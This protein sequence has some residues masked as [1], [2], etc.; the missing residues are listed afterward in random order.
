MGRYS[1]PRTQYLDG[2]GDPYDS[3]KLY[4]Y[5]A[6]TTTALDTY[7]DS[8]LS[9]ANANPVILDSAGRAP[10]SIFLLGRNY[11]VV[12]KDKNDATI[13]T[14]D[15]VTADDEVNTIAAL[16]ALAVPDNGRVVV[17]HGYY[18]QGDHDGSKYIYDSSS[19]ATADG[20]SVITPDSAPATGRWL[21]VMNGEVSV[22]QF[23]AKGDFSTNDY[24]AIQAAIDALQARQTA[25]TSLSSKGLYFPPGFYVVLSSLNFTDASG[26]TLG[27][28]W[29]IRGDGQGTVI[30]V[31][32]S[33]VG[34]SVVDLYRSGQILR[35]NKIE[36][37]YVFADTGVSPAK[38]GIDMRQNTD[39][40]LENV[41]VGRTFS[42]YGIHLN[43]SY[44]GVLNGVH[45]TPDTGEDFSAATD[46]WGAGLYLGNQC[47]ALSI[48]GCNFSGGTVDDFHAAVIQGTIYGVAFSGTS[49]QACAINGSGIYFTNTVVHD[50]TLAGCY[51]EGNDKTAIQTTGTAQA[52]AATT[53][54]LAAGESATDDLFNGATIDI[55]GGT[56]A[57]QRNVITD[58][59]G[60]TKVATVSTWGTNPDA[61]STYDIHPNSADIRFEGQ[62]S[63]SVMENIAVRESLLNS[64][65]YGV[66]FEQGLFH[67]IVLENNTH[68]NGT[69]KSIYRRRD[70]TNM[71]SNIKMRDNRMEDDLDPY[72]LFATSNDP[73]TNAQ[74]ARL[75]NIS[76]TDSHEVEF[77][78]LSVA[79]IPRNVPLGGVT[80]A[81]N[82]WTPST[83]SPTTVVSGNSING[84][85][86][87]LIGPGAGGASLNYTVPADQA[88]KGQVLTFACWMDASAVGATDAP[89]L[90]VT[91]GGTT[92]NFDP[93]FP[94]A[95]WS[96]AQIQTPR[97]YML[98]YKAAAVGHTDED[99]DM[100]FKVKISNWTMEIAQPIICIGAKSLDEMTYVTPRENYQTG[101]AAPSGAVVPMFIGQTYL[102]STT[103]AWY[104][105]TGLTNSDWKIIG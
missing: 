105:A 2:N 31:T 51:F 39:F 45:I 104:Q 27:S 25:D 95:M 46:G 52:G 4:F 100:V 86:T 10:A 62:T 14:E 60:S 55:T 54:T 50:I 26:A 38:Y 11:K 82:L 61:T 7:S 16:S 43:N 91:Q 17:V 24:A 42:D 98:Y 71:L 78:D 35:G 57:G 63:T 12:L 65:C 73:Q 56:G 13:W 5:E 87:W 94:V 96:D 70:V 68:S 53:I 64:E 32:N 18:A 93:Q 58:Y 90:I 23:G 99:A 81:I 66:L 49:F 102:E 69:G 22:R 19:T 76:I 103:P 29:R 47:N 75:F 48:N 36:N 85:E 44:N 83:G 74:Y 59:V 41:R 30:A 92:A 80:K 97:W 67:N 89:G 72:N 28:D 84:V 9:V 101:T 88:T 21:L 79:Q 6:G 34:D 1:N 15:N 20:G 40:V 8:A 33:F 37:I 77:D 3:G